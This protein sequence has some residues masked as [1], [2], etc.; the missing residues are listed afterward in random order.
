MSWSLYR[1]T[2]RL[3][4]PL[5]VGTTPAG[6]LNRCRL[7]LPA[8]ALWGALTAELAQRQ[9]SGFPDYQNAGV[10]IRNNAR[11]TYLYPA[12]RLGQTWRAWLP[13][14]EK[15]N[16]LVWRREDQPS[17]KNDL[18]DRKIRTQLLGTRPGTAIDPSSHTAPEGSLRETECL[19]THWREET[20]PVALVGYVFVKN[21]A[22]P[23]LLEIDRLAV[24]GDTRYGLGQLRREGGCEAAS[25][26]FGRSV[27]LDTPDP[28]VET[29]CLLAH[30]TAAAQGDTQMV[31]QCERIALWDY[32][33][34]QKRVLR[35]NDDLFW[36]PGSRLSSAESGR[37]V[38]R[39]DELGH[40]RRQ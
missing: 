16:G 11:F 34:S 30:G 9:A 1:W 4:S 21:G 27:M 13:R 12:E 2:W 39:I 15:G 26:V 8:R 32:D 33:N 6:S 20:S 18:T 3:E 29:D 35:H 37:V 36:M 25:D 38:W 22:V 40:W 28:T 23:K 24:G 7:Y 17:E 31:G 10:D 5:Y 19:H 14:Y